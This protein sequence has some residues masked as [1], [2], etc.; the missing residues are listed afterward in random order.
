MAYDPL[1]DIYLPDVFYD[2]EYR[3]DEFA[4]RVWANIL[5]RLQYIDLAT[6]MERETFGSQSAIDNGEIYDKSSLLVFLN[7]TNSEVDQ[8]D[9]SSQDFFFFA[10]YYIPDMDHIDAG[11]L[12]ATVAKF[13]LQVQ[14][15]SDLIR[16]DSIP[17]RTMWEPLDRFGKSVF[18]AVMTDLGQRDQPNIVSN[19]ELLEIFTANASRILQETAVPLREDFFDILGP[20][21]PFQADKDAVNSLEIHPA[22]LSANYICQVPHRKPWPELITS[23]LVADLVFLR[24]LWWL[25]NFLAIQWLSRK[26]KS[27]NSCESCFGQGKYEAASIEED[28]EDRKKDYASVSQTSLERDLELG[29]GEHQTWSHTITSKK[30][31]RRN[32]S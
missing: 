29:I 21:T 16:D 1:N 2:S 13:R 5:M 30:L 20:I 7:Q 8:T 18:S 10:G 24:A 14:T 25:V 17:F 12:E 23:I 6:A 19:P 32:S 26:N 31:P 27:M 15:L 11:N 22:V 4:S 3:N 28:S 9:I